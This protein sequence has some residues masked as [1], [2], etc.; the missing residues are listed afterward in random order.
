M[1]YYFKFTLLLTV[2]L[3]DAAPGLE[4]CWVDWFKGTEIDNTQYHKDGHCDLLGS[5]IGCNGK[6][7]I[8]PNDQCTRQ[9]GKFPFWLSKDNLTLSFPPKDL[10]SVPCCI[11]A[12][13]GP[14]NKGYC[15]NKSLGCHN[16]AFWSPFMGQLLTNDWYVCVCL[17]IL[18]RY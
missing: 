1:K 5:K 9:K 3:C 17:P 8:V 18:V 15:T 10:G 11:E 4:R 7:F 2:K 13:C 6:G 16:G 14:R 12:T